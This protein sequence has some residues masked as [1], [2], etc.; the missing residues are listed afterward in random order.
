[1]T[2]PDLVALIIR[3]LRDDWLTHARYADAA[4]SASVMAA[5]D[6]LSGET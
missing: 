4:A 1:M 3:P 2:I 5:P 6:R